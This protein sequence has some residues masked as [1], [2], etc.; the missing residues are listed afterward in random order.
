MFVN[1]I[2]MQT[3]NFSEW[4]VQL[5]NK[6]NYQTIFMNEETFLL[7]EVKIILNCIHNNF[8]NLDL[9]TG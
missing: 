3:L 5:L 9:F 6:E 7:N 4:I 2:N 1:A 8:K